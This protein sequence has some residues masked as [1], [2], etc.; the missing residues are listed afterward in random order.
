MRRLPGISVSMF[1]SYFFF[2]VIEDIFY[3]FP[4]QIIFQLYLVTLS[5]PYLLVYLHPSSTY[6]VKQKKKPL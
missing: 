5:H 6:K 2:S 3:P 1:I 4:N